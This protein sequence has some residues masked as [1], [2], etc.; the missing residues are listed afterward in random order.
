MKHNISVIIPT[1]GELPKLKLALESIERQNM[2]AEIFEVLAIVN[3]SQLNTEEL[4]LVAVQYSPWLKILFIE[5]KGANYARNAGIENSSGEILLFLDDDCVLEDSHFLQKHIQ[6]HR[7]NKNIFAYGGGYNLN[8]GAG[9]FDEIYNYQQ[10]RWLYSGS[11]SY[12]GADFL[13]GGNFS[14]KTEMLKQNN[15]NFDNSIKYGGTEYD[16]FRR[17]QL[18]SLPMRLNNL[19]VV[20]ITQEGLYSLTRKNFLQG[21]GKAIIDSRYGGDKTT[22]VSYEKSEEQSLAKRFMLFYFNYVFWAGYYGYTK[23]YL[24]FATHIFKKFINYLN[25][26]RHK[27][28]GKLSQDIS[29][30]KNKG[31]RF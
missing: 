25:F 1:L 22:V 18:N 17:A 2:E 7:E 6:F 14:I 26:L 28:I 31:E 27:L 21:R 3:G 11:N 29:N 12:G 13:L 23:N 20:H 10:M 30:K 16:F 15:L 9:F 4:Q 24:G 5:N 19:E 8:A